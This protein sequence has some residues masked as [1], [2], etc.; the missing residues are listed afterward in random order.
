MLH[1]LKKKT[2]KSLPYGTQ[3]RFF[4]FLDSAITMES[5]PFKSYWKRYCVR[6]SASSKCVLVVVWNDVFRSANICVAGIFANDFNNRIP[7]SKS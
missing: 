7:A 3:V 4:Y 6:R 1:E 2:Q 5:L